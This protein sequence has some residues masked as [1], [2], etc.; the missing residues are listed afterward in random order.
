MLEYFIDKTKYGDGDVICGYLKG[1]KVCPN[2]G[3]VAAGATARGAVTHNQDLMTLNLTPNPSYTPPSASTTANVPL[4]APFACPLSMKE[5]SGSVPFIALRPCGCV[6]ADAAVRAVIPNLTKGIAAKTGESAET[7]NGAAK[8]PTPPSASETE[9]V[10]CP[11]CGQMFDPTAPT[12]IMRIN[13]PKEVQEV[14]LELLLTTRAAAKSSKKRKAEA[15][16]KDMNEAPIASKALKRE[17]ERELGTSS[18]APVSSA[19][20][21][22]TPP[23]PGSVKE[24]LAEQERKRLAQQAGM[25]DAVR[26]MFK[27]KDTGVEKKNGA[28]EFFG[29][30]FTRVS[31]PLHVV[32][33]QSLMGSMQR[34][35]FVIFVC[36]ISMHS[37]MCD[38]LLPHAGQRKV[39]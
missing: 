29:R 17:K 25:S 1:F 33:A 39:V 34:S 14:L 7:P 10:A 18:P 15:V 9:K 8:A 27:P 23:V 21:R 36:C 11:N 37:Y 38:L 32:V 6:F 35:V 2:P 31:L 5:M 26:A 3:I 12:S 13:P 24:K 30:T 4:R 16:A 22:G 19:N 20:G 28:A